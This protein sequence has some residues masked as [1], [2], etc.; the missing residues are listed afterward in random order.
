MKYYENDGR[1]ITILPSFLKEAFFMQYKHSKF[2]VDVKIGDKLYLVYNTMSQGLL[3]IDEEHYN[4]Y[5]NIITDSELITSK[6]IE[7]GFWIEEQRNELN[8]LKIKHRQAKFS[9]SLINVT[10]KTTNDCNFLCKYCY[11]E[12][13]PKVLSNEGTSRLIAFF[14]NQIEN[15]KLKHFFIH[16]FGGE[17]LLNVEPILKIENY[18]E[19]KDVTFKSAMTTNGYLLNEKILSQLCQT[20]VGSLQITIDGVQEQHDTTRVLRNGKGTFR[21]IIDNIK[22]YL[23]VNPTIKIII[24]YN[25]NKSNHDIT[26][27]LQYLQDNDLRRNNIKL[28]F[29]PTK[30]HQISYTNED[31]FYNNAEE[32]ASQL[33]RIYKNLLAYKF[34][35]PMYKFRGI[36]CEFDNHNNFLIETNGEIYQCSSSDRQ[37]L[38]YLGEINSNGIIKHNKPNFVR[39]MLREPFD[40][41]KCLECKVLPMCMGG[42]NYEEQ[43]G[44]EEC[45]PEKYIINDLVKYYYLSQINNWR[46]VKDANNYQ[47]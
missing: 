10:I 45:I 8:E 6:F 26:D 7:Y 9:D 30:R 29:N 39:K 34:S 2:N 13:E 47:F 12:H 38:F 31:I 15:R 32:Y 44:M 16:W 14:E 42:C 25:V 35:I 41:E 11:Q 28:H 5:R 4:M 18:L 20:K 33:L 17:P 21:I 22:S 46:E 37:G 40:K 19:N 43:Q 36:N 24:R 3:E 23:Q 1:I 27:F